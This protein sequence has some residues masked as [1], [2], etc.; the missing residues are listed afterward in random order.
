LG[1]YHI[2]FN[3]YIYDHDNKCAAEYAETFTE[4]GEKKQEEE[5]KM[6]LEL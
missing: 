1:L 2:P 4:K 5:K 3:L 6:P